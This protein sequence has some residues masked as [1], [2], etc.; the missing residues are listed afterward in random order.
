MRTGLLAAAA[1]AALLISA[2]AEAAP[3]SCRT[4][5]SDN[6]DVARTVKDFFAAIQRADLP[7]ATRLTAPSF[8]SFDVQKH[9]TGAELFAMVGGAQKRGAKL[10]FGIDKVET[11][12]DCNFAWAVWRNDGKINATPTL[13]LESAMLR[14][15]TA[16]WRFEFYHSTKVDPPK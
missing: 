9:F 4:K 6:E 11:H 16:G 7:A 12:V 2:G 5:A 10:E 15:T 1:C 8:H 13:W 14:R 3:K